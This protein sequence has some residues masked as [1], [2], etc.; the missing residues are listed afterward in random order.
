[1]TQRPSVVAQVACGLGIATLVQTMKH[2]CIG[3]TTF[4]RLIRP[5]P[6]LKCYLAYRKNASSPLLKSFISICLE[7]RRDFRER[8]V[9]K[10]AA[11]KNTG[12]NPDAGGRAR[13]LAKNV[14]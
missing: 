12:Q 13:L 5:T 6:T 9:L 8:R 7:L 4:H 10:N 14:G 1:M 3:G 2:L 11:V